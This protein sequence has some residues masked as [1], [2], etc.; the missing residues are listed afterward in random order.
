MDNK[1]EKN[2]IYAVLIVFLLSFGILFFPIK[3]TLPEFGAAT[4]MQDALLGKAAAPHI[5]VAAAL[6]PLF[7]VTA[8]NPQSIVSFL[9]LFPPVLLAITSLLLYFAIRRLNI[10]R[11]PAAFAALLFPLSLAAFAFL[12]GVYSSANLAA[13]LFAAFLFFFCSFASQK[14]A[15]MVIPAILFAALSAYVN[16]A[17][18]IAG[19]AAVIAF[20]ANAYLKADKRLLKFAII[21]V[22]FAA[23]MY[24]STDATGLYFS[25]KNIGNAFALMPFILAAASVSAVVFFFASA[26]VDHFLLFIAGI[27][28]AVF[29]PLAGALLLCVPAAGGV[30]AAMEEKLPK[31]AKLVSAFFISFFALFGLS[32]ASGSDA[33]KSAAIAGMLSVLAPLVLHFYE[34]RNHR[35]LPAFALSL[36]AISLAFSLFYALPPVREHYPQY[37]DKDMSS[38]LLSLSG[39]NAQSIAILGSADAA[40]FYSPGSQFSPEQDYS[41]YLLT[42]APKPHSGTYAVIS[43]AYLDDQLSGGNFDSF[44][45][46]NNFTSGTSNFALFFSPSGRLVA[47]EIAAD[48]SFALKDGALLDGTGRQYA[49]EPLSRMI[50]LVP[51]RPFYN[52]SNRMIVLEEG[53]P[54]P[55]FMKIYSGS[56]N[57]L[58]EKGEFGKVSVYK[59]N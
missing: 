54:L 33:V 24:F 29:S 44:F 14:K 7:G 51:G 22:V 57:E 47:R 5:A 35:L 18:G 21:A 48:G 2:D 49:S 30:S 19:I 45:Y 8:S 55:Y 4:Q 38:A 3:S 27:F 59:V 28:T 42:G 16:A 15:M 1:F 9:L 46:S 43:L 6:A 36:V 31:G 11:T 56:A 53:A 13:V 32:L 58:T 52:S 26:S 23:A 34:Y 12:P 41:S 25:A 50:M 37:S 10:R 39:A 40:R 17:F 20:A